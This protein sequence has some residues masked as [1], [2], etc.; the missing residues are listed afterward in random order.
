V[1]FVVLRLAAALLLLLALGPQPAGYYDALHWVV[2]LVAAYGVYRTIQDRYV[3]W[4]WFLGITA[5]ALNPF[6]RLPLDHSMWS[7]VYT[8]AAV[9]MVISIL[10]TWRR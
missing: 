9:I 5:F 6:V 4:A 2:F 3:I 10:G 7:A 8:G 1:I